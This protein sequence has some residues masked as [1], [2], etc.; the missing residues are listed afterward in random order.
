[1]SLASNIRTIGGI[2]LISPF[3]SIKRLVEE[4]VGKIATKFIP[5]IDMYKNNITIRNIYCPVI[6]IHGEKD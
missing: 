4:K 3:A 2:I 5:G 1:M 6:I